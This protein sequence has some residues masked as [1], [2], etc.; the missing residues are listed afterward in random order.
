MSP[1]AEWS[2]RTYP[3]PLGAGGVG[4]IPDNSDAQH[5]PS[6]RRWRF[7]MKLSPFFFT[8]GGICLFDPHVFRHSSPRRPTPPWPAGPRGCSRLNFGRCCMNLY[9]H[10]ACSQAEHTAACHCYCHT[11]IA[12]QLDLIDY[13]LNTMYS[14]IA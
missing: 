7:V 11:A 5:V 8:T 13:Y 9:C 3:A 10:A 14:S 1:V 4:S 6:F 12:A 2:R